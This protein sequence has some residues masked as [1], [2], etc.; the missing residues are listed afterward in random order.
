VQVRESVYIKGLE[1]VGVRL[2][3][4]RDLGQRAE[5]VAGSL[6]DKLPRRRPRHQFK[7]SVKGHANLPV[8]H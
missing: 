1:P 3:D 4:E 5:Q 8:L 7:Q 6:L 2:G